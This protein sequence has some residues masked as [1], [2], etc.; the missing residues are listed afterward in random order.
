RL[1]SFYK[2]SLGIALTLS[3]FGCRSDKSSLGSMQEQSVPNVIIILADDAGYSDFGFMGSEDILSPNLDALANDGVVFTDAHVTA[4]VCSPSRAGLLTGRYQQ[5][6]GHE[7]NLEPNQ[8]GAF[9]HSEITIAEFLK[10][11]GY[12]TSIFGK[13]HLGEQEHQHPLNNGFDYFWGFLAGSRS[14][15]PSDGSKKLGANHMT[16]ENKTPVEFEGYLTDVIGDMAV[17]KINANDGKNPFFMYLSFN[18]PHTPMHAKGEVVAKFGEEHARPI[19]AAMVWSMDEAVGKVIAALKEK[20]EYENTLIFFLS[21]NGGA[22]NNGS[23]VG[24][25][26]GW[27]GNQFE[28][29]T[30]V[31]FTVTWKGTIPSGGQFDGLT[32]SLDIYKTATSFWNYSGSPDKEL[33]GADLIPYLHGLKKGNPHKELFWRKDEMATIR[34]NDYKYILL[35]DSLSVLYNLNEDLAE[36]IDISASN[37]D[38]ASSM[39][40][41]LLSWEQQL[42]NPLWVEP[43]AW[44]QVTTRIYEDLMQNKPNNIKEPHDMKASLLRSKR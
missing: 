14:Y 13:W 25:L 9:D 31:P 39:K 29:G 37:L 2:F 26:K 40:S 19:Y 18:A 12:E 38:L 41:D 32:S 3:L 7:C 1:Y 24:P 23:S 17:K 30:R 34:V 15:F 20:G 42:K 16:Q 43:A 33:D 5:R 10:S 36:V 22:H 8:G 6:F 4:S 21:D 35:K 44:N 11:Q 27:K 28:G